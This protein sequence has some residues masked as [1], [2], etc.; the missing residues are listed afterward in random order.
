MSVADILEEIERVEDD[1]A[2]HDFGG[3]QS[4]KGNDFAHFWLI[5]RML[6]VEMAGPADY[7]FVCEY[8][9]DVAEFDSGSSPSTVTLYQLKKKEDGYWTPSDLTGQTKNSKTPKAGKPLTKLFKSVTAF[10]SL[11][12]RGTFISNAK[13]D[14]SLGSAAKSTNDE[15]I[16]ISD[17]DQEHCD[18]LRVGLGQLEGMLPADVDLSCLELRSVPL[19]V[20]DLEGHTTGVMFGFLQQKAPG[21]A[22]QASSLVDAIY[23]KLRS[24]A[25]HTN[26]S[27]TWSELVERRGFGK[28]AF[29]QAV[30]SLASIPD[31]TAETDRLLDK[32]AKNWTTPHTIRVRMALSA[33]LRDKVLVGDGNRWQIESTPIR[34]LCAH[35]DA[36]GQP[37]FECFE[38][39][40]E[41][42]RVQL[43]E[44][45]DIQITALAIHEMIESWTQH[46][47]LA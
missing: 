36:T 2:H 44:M 45:P 10:K 24:S 35:A 23:V 13:F 27:K 6:D 40:A 33:C 42:L 39:V 19:S 12:A 28:L 4:N 29:Q 7:M 14:V 32:L 26:K 46:P 9:Q 3:P 34:A 30:Q 22:N 11:K 47:T 38:S 25:R 16:A 5:V 37:E 17:W 1:D 20:S 21:H 41:A 31:K 15:L 18:A 43:P 8:V